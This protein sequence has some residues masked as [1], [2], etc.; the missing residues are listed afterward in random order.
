MVSWMDRW[1]GKG[2]HTR[3]KTAGSFVEK[4]WFTDCIHLSLKTLPLVV[5]RH[6]SAG[7]VLQRVNAEPIAGGEDRVALANRGTAEPLNP[8]NTHRR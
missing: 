1:S 5:E 6:P 4:G 7:G 3:G 2:D 8:H